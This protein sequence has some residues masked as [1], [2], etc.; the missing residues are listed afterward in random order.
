MV[1]SSKGQYVANQATYCSYSEFTNTS[2]PTRAYVC[3]DIGTNVPS[4]A[5]KSTFTSTSSIFSACTRTYTNARSSSCPC[6]CSRTFINS[7]AIFANS[8]IASS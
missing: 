8:R 5:Y 2:P 6:S 3:I 1:F 7:A 4:C